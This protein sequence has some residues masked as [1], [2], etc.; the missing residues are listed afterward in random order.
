VVGSHPFSRTVV[1]PGEGDGMTITG[2]YH[3]EIGRLMGADVRVTGRF[4]DTGLPDR[5]LAA[6][7]YEVVAVDGET[8]VLGFLERDDAGHY[9][10]LDDAKTRIGAVPETLGRR[11]GALVW[12][13]VDENAGV[14]RY[15]IL[16]EAAK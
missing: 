7:S 3:A 9:L 2:P 6:T 12:V 10:R 14:A 11:L 16:R 5:S 13:V 8:V 1:D 4:E 15:G